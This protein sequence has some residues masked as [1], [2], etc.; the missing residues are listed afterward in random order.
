MT[1]TPWSG[2]SR[3]TCDL[4]KSRSSRATSTSSWN[5][6]GSYAGAALGPVSDVPDFVLVPVNGGGYVGVE[7]G[8]PWRTQ[9]FV[10]DGKCVTVGHLRACRGAGDAAGR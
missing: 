4:T 10:F 9:R 6:D 7:H 5:E 8:A 1:A 3:A 2:G